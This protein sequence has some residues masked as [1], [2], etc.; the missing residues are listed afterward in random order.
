[1]LGTSVSLH[2]FQS[3]IPHYLDRIVKVVGC[4]LAAAQQ[5]PA[6]KR[7]VHVPSDACAAAGFSSHLQAVLGAATSA[8]LSMLFLAMQGQHDSPPQKTNLEELRHI[9]LLWLCVLPYI[10]VVYVHA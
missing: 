7:I 10:Q 5:I 4:A 9:P 8:V 6:V 1:M 3:C 2:N